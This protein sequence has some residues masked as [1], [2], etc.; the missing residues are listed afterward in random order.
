MIKAIIVEDE[1][2]HSNRLRKLIAQTDNDI[3][4]LAVCTEVEEAV[5]VIREQ[6]PELLFLD[7][8]INGELKA[9]F[10]LLKLLA[11]DSAMFDVIFTTA[12]IDSNI[13]EIRRCGLDYIAKPYVEEE[14]S[15]ALGK[16]WEKKEG[17]I[18][19]RQ[20]KTLLN[21]LVTED[22]EDQM[23]WLSDKVQDFPVRVRDVIY[24][25]SATQPKEHTKV[26][27]LQNDKLTH[28]VSSLNIGRWE[29]MLAKYRF[30]RIHR[31]HLVN[32]RH[33]SSFNRSEN[34]ATLG[35]VNLHFPVSRTG[36]EKLGILMNK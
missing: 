29:E 4:V 13:I 5:S 23:V 16:F 30:C 36:K 19:I 24:C 2:R 8:C 34:M 14:L 27:Y 12:H 17:H 3:K 11:D 1:H 10:R 21:N 9:G 20:V 35:K 6:K 25:E 7:I 28:V 26:H 33:I 18:G 22:L 15:D 32:F 31:Q